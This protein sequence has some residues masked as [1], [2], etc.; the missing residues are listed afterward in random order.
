MLT[1]MR[2]ATVARWHGRIPPPGS[3]NCPPATLAVPRLR[4]QDLA[5]RTHAQLTESLKG[6]TAQREFNELN[7]RFH[8]SLYQRADSAV[9]L[10]TIENLASQAE[11]I[12]MHFDLRRGP[13]QPH[14]EAILR[15]CENRHAATAARRHILTAY[16]AM[17]PDDHRIEPESSLGVVLTTFRYAD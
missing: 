2:R 8:M 6:E 16:Q 9:L 4:G 14:H 13:A 11:R 1:R 10:R 5:D 7:R 17:M 3:S 15:A 12:R